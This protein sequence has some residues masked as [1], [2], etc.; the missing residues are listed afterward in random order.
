MKTIAKWIFVSLMLVCSSA[1][2]NTYT[3]DMSDTWWNENEPGW[4]VNVNHQRDVA[5]LTFFVYGNAGRV[6][7]YTGETTITAGETV[8]PRLP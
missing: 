6:A 3:S 7:W 1:F 8:V 2:A 4:G 5:F